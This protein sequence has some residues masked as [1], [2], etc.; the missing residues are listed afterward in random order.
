MFVADLA[1]KLNVWNWQLDLLYYERE[2]KFYQY[3]P[4]I[5]FF[6]PVLSEFK[7]SYQLCP[8]LSFEGRYLSVIRKTSFLLSSNSFPNNL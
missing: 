4:Q 2:F 3:D 1:V 8:S 6:F 5:E 7:N